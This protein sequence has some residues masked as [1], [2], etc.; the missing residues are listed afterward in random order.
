MTTK[1]IV[2]RYR[3]KPNQEESDILL[4]PEANF[5]CAREDYRCEGFIDMWFE[6][7]SDHDAQ[8][9]AT[10]FKVIKTGQEV[11]ENATHLSS[12]MLTDG[13]LNHIYKVYQKRSNALRE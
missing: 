7:D 4:D 12:V 13:F 2:L 9:L 8:K 10:R 5:L 3:I 1:R 6:V 11:P